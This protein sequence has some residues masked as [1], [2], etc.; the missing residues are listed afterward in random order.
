MEEYKRFTISLQQDL[1]MKFENFRNRIGLSK[2]DAI[3]KA[4]NLFMTQDKNIKI[5]FTTYL[6]RIGE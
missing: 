6:T 4:M 5:Y 2:S 1:Y 3:R